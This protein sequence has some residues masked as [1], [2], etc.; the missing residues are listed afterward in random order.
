FQIERG[1][2]ISWFASFHMSRERLR[3]DRQPGHG[4]VLPERIIDGT[5]DR[6]A[7][8]IDPAFAGAFEPEWIERARCV[9]RDQ[10]LDRGYFAR[11]GHEIIGERDG[12]GIAA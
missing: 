3:S 2:A 7:R 6:G 8:A 1:D 9:F 11:S 5:G 12:Q 4:A 10:D